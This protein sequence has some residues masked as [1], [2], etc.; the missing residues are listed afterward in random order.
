MTSSAPDLSCSSAKSS[1]HLSLYPTTS[2]LSITLPL[3]VAPSQL[4]DFFI[5][6]T[7][8]SDGVL[9]F[10]P[11]FPHPFTVLGAPLTDKPAAVALHTS[12]SWLDRLHPITPA[13]P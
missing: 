6:F 10:L 3:S 8:E 13:L 4:G 7:A 12:P 2:P 1:A 11:L 9:S 5:A